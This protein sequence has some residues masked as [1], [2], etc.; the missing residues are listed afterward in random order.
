MASEAT[1]STELIRVEHLSRQFGPTRAVRDVSFS[2][3]RGEVLGFLGLNGAGKTTTMRI[4]AGALAPS[5]GRVQVDGLDLLERPRQAKSRLGY[6]PEQ[7]PL[8]R[9]MDVDGYLR[10]C[11]RLRRVPQARIRAALDTAKARCGL[12]GVGK[13]LIGHLSR[14]YQ[15]RVGIAQA[16]VHAPAVVILDEPTV[17]LD[18]VQV[19]EIRELIRE[20]GRERGVI[21]S[22]HLLAEV[23]SVCSRVQI[24][25]EG[26]LVFS[27]SLPELDRH[28]RQR[29][30]LVG[31]RNPPP[32]R[33][34]AALTGVEQVE[35]LA[36]DRFRLHHRPGVDPS[37]ELVERCV[38]GGWELVE[39]SPERPGLEQVFVE[40][41][42]REGTPP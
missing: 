32:A 2:L 18:P 29:A 33:E 19:R 42:L 7:P 16:L 41:T 39:L 6:L 35:S 38:S 14:G 25:H 37:G 21:L 27:A 22:T 31:L 17:G 15:Q 8:Y 36:Q 24:I 3:G 11:A 23:E 26:T 10:F 30:L 34:L 12:D 28:R 40:L 9:D 4:L 1:T 5:A 20:L 13:R